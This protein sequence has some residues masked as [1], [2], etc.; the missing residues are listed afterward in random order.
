M[1]TLASRG[2]NIAVRQQVPYNTEILCWTT[3]RTLFLSHSNHPLGDLF[4]TPVLQPLTLSDNGHIAL[5][6]TN[7]IKVFL[8]LPNQVEVFQ[9]HGALCSWKGKKWGEAR[10]YIL[11]N[12]FTRDQRWHQYAEPSVVL[13]V[14]SCGRDRWQPIRA[15]RFPLPFKKS[16]P[17]KQSL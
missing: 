11:K 10:F 14:S 9:P 7:Q 8:A 17:K 4:Q 2:W 12:N 1:G 5:P 15:G 13:T 3:L 6:S 16:I